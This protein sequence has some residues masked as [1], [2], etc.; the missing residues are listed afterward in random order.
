LGDVNQLWSFPKNVSIRARSARSGFNA[1]RSLT[2]SLTH[3][4]FILRSHAILEIRGQLIFRRPGFGHWGRDLF[5]L[6]VKGFSIVLK[7][8]KAHPSNWTFPVNEAFRFENRR[9]AN[10]GL[11]D[12][13]LLFAQYVVA[14]LPHATRIRFCCKGL[15]RFIDLAVNQTVLK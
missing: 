5:T 4:G 14:A 3:A 12:F 13:H 15:G 8:G 10:R 9:W 11:F 1:E 6:C 7:K 2:E